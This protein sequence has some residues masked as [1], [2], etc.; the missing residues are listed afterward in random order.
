MKE[1]N[2]ENGINFGMPDIFVDLISSLSAVRALSE[3]NYQTAS[4][5]EL[6]EDALR[7]LIQNQDMERCSFFH[8][9][10]QGYLVY[11]AG[12][13]VREQNTGS[14]GDYKPLQ[15]K[16]GEG[17]IGLAAQSGELQHCQNCS[18][19]KRFLSEVKISK[20]VLLG[21]IISVPVFT[22][23]TK[24]VGVLNISHPQPY[25]FSGWHI[26]LLEI[27]KNMLGRLITNFHLFQKMEDQ[28]SMRTAKLEQALSDLQSLKEHFES[29]SMIDQLTGL[30]NRR[31]FYSQVELALANTK[32]YGQSLCLLMLDLDNF[33]AA[34]D[35][36]G[37]GFGDEVL[38]K[39]AAVMRHHVRDSDILARFGGEEFVVIFTNTD[40]SD[41][42]L[43]AE[44]IRKTVEAIVWEDKADFT[45]TVSIGLYCL[46][47]DEGST[48][49]N[50][51]ID[52]LI[53]YA[54]VALYAAKEQGRNGV[55]T[56][57]ESM[58]Q[59]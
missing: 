8:L 18:E 54:D 41:G 13:S 33:K 4:E 10:E 34:N 2:R 37:H 48:A 46:N 16:I 57:T 45:Q 39:F 15:F 53:Q 40:C 49:S 27:Y 38:T 24:L 35:I 28:I 1:N 11:L 5:T 6:I 29:I 36:Y 47:N 23:G 9:D 17:I 12:L 55:V 19:D 59:K 50:M 52:K 31:Y 14:H 21:S 58:L 30:Y 3:L 43:F 22:S 7:A 25:H 32:R 51:D 26:R 44:R 42:T 20:K 56:F